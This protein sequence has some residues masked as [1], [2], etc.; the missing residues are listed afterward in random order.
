MCMCTYKIVSKWTIPLKYSMC[1]TLSTFDNFCV[2]N[3]ISVELVDNALSMLRTTSLAAKLHPGDLHL[4]PPDVR[5]QGG[6]NKT[7]SL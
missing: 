6:C 3:N 2:F 7:G 1:H 5:M 4:A